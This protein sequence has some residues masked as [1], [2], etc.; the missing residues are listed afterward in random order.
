MVRFL[1]IAFFFRN[2]ASSPHLFY[3]LAFHQVKPSNQEVKFLAEGDIVRCSII[4]NLVNS[5]K[6][7][8]ER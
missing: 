2:I 4:M 1:N 5:I 7:A 8:I 3:S 6:L